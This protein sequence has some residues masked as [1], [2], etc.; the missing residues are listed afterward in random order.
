MSYTTTDINN[1]LQYAK[2]R[3]TKELCKDPDILK[4]MCPSSPDCITWKSNDSNRMWSK[5]CTYNPNQVCKI[6]SDCPKEDILTKDVKCISNP[7]NPSDPNK[8]CGFCT[9][10]QDSGNC[11]FNNREICL[12]Y[13]EIPYRCDSVGCNYIGSQ[14]GTTGP[15]KPYLEWTTPKTGA[16]KC[17]YGDFVTRMYAENPVGRPNLSEKDM[18]NLPP[19]FI[20]D[21]S[22]SNMYISQDYCSY[23]NQSYGSGSCSTDSDCPND[24]TC[25]QSVDQ[26]YKICSNTE[27]TTNTDCISGDICYKKNST[28]SKGVCNGQSSNCWTTVGQDVGEMLVGKTIFNG[29]SRLFKLENPF[30]CTTDATNFFKETVN[31]LPKSP[32]NISILSDNRFFKSKKNIG[33]NFGGKN[34]NLYIIE[35]KPEAGMKKITSSGFD[36]DEVE[37]L[38]PELIEYKDD[39]KY[40]KINIEHAK[41]NKDMKRIYLTLNSNDLIIKNVFKELLISKKK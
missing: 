22:T 20:Y 16:S 41:K 5:I 15:S 17:I 27:C 3:L 11:A 24:G 29:F 34:I 4:K 6:D 37:K 21:S 23:Y 38:Y 1:A 28:D 32:E 2:D 8:Y 30:A 19:P 33:S 14:T 26:S 7:D 10:N 13:S 25:H 31:M 39:K 12:N 18:K 40:I 9:N 36:A 35:W